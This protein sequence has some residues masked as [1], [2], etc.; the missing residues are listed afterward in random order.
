M[1]Y[2]GN[3]R[4]IALYVV[5]FAPI[6]KHNCKDCDGSELCKVPLCT[7]QGK[8]KST[9]DTAYFGLSICFRMSSACGTEL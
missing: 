2:L 9:K 3:R 7:K 6:C 4:I 1:R 8:T 5:Q